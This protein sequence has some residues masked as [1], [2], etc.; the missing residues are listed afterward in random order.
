V[1]FWDEFDTTVDG[2]KLAWLASFLGPMQD[3]KFLIDQ[4]SRY[5]PK[6]VFVFAGSVFSRFEQ[7]RFLNWL[8]ESGKPGRGLFRTTGG[9]EYDPSSSGTGTAKGNDLVNGNGHQSESPDFRFKLTQSG[10]S[11][12][13]EIP[14]SLPASKI[15]WAMAKGRDFKSRITGVLDIA[16]VDP[17]TYEE[18]VFGLEEDTDAWLFRRAAAVR[19]SFEKHADLLN[20][21]KELQI[22]ES[23]LFS[24]LTVQAFEHGYRSI[25]NMVRMSSLNQRAIADGSVVPTEAQVRIHCRTDLFSTAVKV[26]DADFQG[27]F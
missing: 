3:G 21:D 1:V 12:L 19:Q 8:Q 22:S 18:L 25:E 2:T 9:A 17:R 5:L 10:T 23:T 7:I 15:D 6:C 20:S 14:V 16:S 24:F 27:L 11:A 4:T 26:N 13:R